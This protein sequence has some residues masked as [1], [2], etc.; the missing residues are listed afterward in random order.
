MA[1]PWDAEQRQ[2]IGRRLLWARELVCPNRSE[3]ARKMGVDNGHICRIETGAKGPS[4]TLLQNM[5]HALRISYDYVVEGRLV[6]V[7]PELLGLLIAYHPE[8]LAEAQRGSRGTGYLPSTS[9]KPRKPQPSWVRAA[10]G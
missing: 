10:T 7:D 2:A 8:L 1:K 4:I 5:C 3:F 6:G 9:G